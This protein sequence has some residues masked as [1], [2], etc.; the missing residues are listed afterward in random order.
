MVAILTKAG[1]KETT[2]TPVYKMASHD[3]KLYAQYLI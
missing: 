3:G 2:I 1:D